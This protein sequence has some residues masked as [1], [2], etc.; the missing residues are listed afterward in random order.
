MIWHRATINLD[1]TIK[2]NRSSMS[3][4]VQRLRLIVAFLLPSPMH[5]VCVPYFSPEGVPGGYCK[6]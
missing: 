2:I 6:Q 3:N 4:H 1:G 5:T